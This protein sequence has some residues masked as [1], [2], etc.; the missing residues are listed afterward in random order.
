[1]INNRILFDAVEYN[2]GDEKRINHLVKVNAYSR[3]ISSLEG[4][5]DKTGSIID[6]S[7][8]LH[9]IAIHI[10]EQ[11]YGSSS[12]KYQ[13]IEGP[14]IAMSILRKYDLSDDFKERVCYLIANHHTYDNI[15]GIDY[16]ILVEADFIVNA[17]EDNLSQQAITVFREKYFKTKSGIR[18]LN[19]LFFE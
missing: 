4:V 14:E 3:L 6:V 12:G 19:N 7:S 18:I 15:D 16:Q 2:A 13:E 1:M 11:K 10:C 8:A 17:C 9:D 5:D